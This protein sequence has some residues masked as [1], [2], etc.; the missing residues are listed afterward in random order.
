MTKRVVEKVAAFKRVRKKK[1]S[2][3]VSRIEEVD[4]KDINTLR[5]NITDRG[6]IASRRM[7]GLCPKHQRAVAAAIKKA[8]EA[9]LLP[10]VID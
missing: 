7:T 9:S 5:K 8:R 2:V 1:C 4:Y 10:H 6:K 3:C